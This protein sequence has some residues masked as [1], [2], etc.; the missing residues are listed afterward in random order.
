[1]SHDSAQAASSGDAQDKRQLARLVLDAVR[2]TA[3][4]YGLWFAEAVHQCGL[5]RALAMERQAGSRLEHIM[6]GRLSRTFGFE[7]ED[8]LPAFL[9]QMDEAELRALAESL[10]ANW[11]AADGVWFQAAE[12]ESATGMHDAKRI[13][14]TCW[15]RF[16]PFE[17]MR[18]RELLDLPPATTPLQGLDQLATALQHRLY[19]HLNVQDIVDRTSHGFTF[20]MRQ[21][22]VQKARKR[23]G[24]EDYPCK[25]GGTVEYT[26]FAA[27]FHPEI[28][29]ECIAC[30]PDPH[31][32]EWHCAWRFSVAAQR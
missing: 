14:D 9:L 25:S 19:A 24:L 26:T 17:A 15:S 28:R 20:R 23:K 31:P 6:L 32:E 22:R 12:A 7:L 29:T 2:R 1:M 4:H 13:N 27:A 8:G 30:P 10:A 3:V 21:C 5:E 11:L 18:I 16:S